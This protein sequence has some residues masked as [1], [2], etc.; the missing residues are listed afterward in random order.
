MD[1]LVA[2]GG[3]VISFTSSPGW[4]VD[5]GGREEEDKKREGE[6]MMGRRKEY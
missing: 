6:Q 1:V 3:R 4:G 5:A 2:V